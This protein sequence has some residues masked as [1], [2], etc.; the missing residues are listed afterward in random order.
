MSTGY[1]IKDQYAKHFLTLTV[2]DWV[3]VFSRQGCRDVI[4]DS[5]Q[6]CIKEKG[7]RLYSYVIMTNH[8][9]L[10]VSSREGKLSD[11]IRDFKKFTARKI[12]SLINEEAESRRE[13]LLHR[14]EWNAGKMNGAAITSFGRM[15]IMLWK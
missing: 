6:Y 5:L 1:Q 15:K 7:L 4:V 13:W 14:F 8:V 11:A 2:V 3:D 12:I 9:H 10:I